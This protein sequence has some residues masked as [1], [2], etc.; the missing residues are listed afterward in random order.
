MNQ[1]IEEQKNS[2]DSSIDLFIKSQTALT[3]ATSEN[4]IPYCATCFYSFLENQES[5]VFKSNRETQHIHEGIHNKYVAGT[6][7]P[8]KSKIGEIKGVQFNGIFIEPS[9]NLLNEAKNS[10]YKKYPLAIDFKGDFWIIQLTN[11]KFTDNTLG[12]GKKIKWK[13]IIIP[14]F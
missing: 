1:Q 5:F 9:G 14:P 3:I 2:I 13:K 10:Y 7:V 6:I 8:E 11:L 4:N 12:F